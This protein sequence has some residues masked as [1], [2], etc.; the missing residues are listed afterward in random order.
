MSN[1]QVPMDLSLAGSSVQGILQA[2]ILEWVAI[3]FSRRSF[4]PRDWTQVSCIANRFFTIWATRETQRNGRCY[5]IQVC[6]SHEQWGQT[7]QNIR[8]WIREMFISGLSKENVWLVFKTPNS[9]MV[10]TKRILQPNLESG[11]QDVRLFLIGV[12]WNDRVLLQECCV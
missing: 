3:P 12:W 9:P 5:Q 8:V 2:R 10:S 11:L 4:W 7:N 1:S 6:V